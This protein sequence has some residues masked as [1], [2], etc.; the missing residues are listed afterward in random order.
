M[1]VYFSPSINTFY[2]T[3]NTLKYA[4]NAKNIKTVVSHNILNI[5]YHI[6]NYVNIINNLKNEIVQLNQQIIAKNK[7]GININI[8]NNSFETT[9]KI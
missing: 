2:D 8:I 1:I 7:I 3:Y 6:N 4:N 5:Q 9:K